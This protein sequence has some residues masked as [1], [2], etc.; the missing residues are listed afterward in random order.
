MIF[1][2]FPLAALVFFPDYATSAA[3]AATSDTPTVDVL[4]VHVSTVDV[5]H[6][7]APVQTSVEKLTIIKE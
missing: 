1:L 6:P 3:V 7:D 4:T 5:L 2:I